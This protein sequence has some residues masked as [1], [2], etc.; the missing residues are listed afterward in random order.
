MNYFQEKRRRCNKKLRLSSEKNMD[1]KIL[2]REVEKQR[3][4][5]MASLY[6]SLRSL[7][8]LEFIKVCLF[9]NP[10]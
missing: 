7:L 4:Q 8:P 10:N 6:A 5:E 1:Q 2:H 9:I 3:R